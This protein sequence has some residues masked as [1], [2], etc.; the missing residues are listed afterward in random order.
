MS[1]IMFDIKSKEFE[2][3]LMKESDTQVMSTRNAATTNATIT[4][5]G[6]SENAA[7]NSEVDDAALQ[8]EMAAND[9]TA[10][11]GIASEEAIDGM[12]E[13]GMPEEGVPEDV[14]TDGM[15]EGEIIVDDPMMPIMDGG[16]DGDFS[17]DE[18]MYMD[19]SMETMTEAKDP[20]LSSWPYVIG[21]SAAV[22]AVSVF[23]GVLLARRKIKKGIELYED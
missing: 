3:A 12:T 2:V 10:T 18:G 15:V 21:I 7:T 17:F 5:V 11:D 6:V 14:V 22:L 1:E 23:L 16:M 4:N 13:E 20:L 19:P 9:A 8:E